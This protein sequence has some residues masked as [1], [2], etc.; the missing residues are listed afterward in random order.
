MLG[1]ALNVAMLPEDVVGGS[2]GEMRERWWG[3]MIVEFA[4]CNNQMIFFH[5]SKQQQGGI[6][7]LIGHLGWED[8]PLYNYI[9]IHI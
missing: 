9:N 4:C 6:L 7:Y 5:S 8:R 3:G 2:R 1:G